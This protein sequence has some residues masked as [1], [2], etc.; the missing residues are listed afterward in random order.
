MTGVGAEKGK[1]RRIF[2]GYYSNRIPW[3]L[4]TIST[5]A[6]VLR[7]FPRNCLSSTTFIE[8]K[9]RATGVQRCSKRKLPV[10]TADW[11]CHIK[12]QG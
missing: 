8:I 5:K 4:S 3:R 10:K 7:L 1:R 6:S 12:Q 11:R 2:F 9:D